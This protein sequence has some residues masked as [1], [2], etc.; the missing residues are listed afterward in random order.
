MAQVQA[1]SYI[2]NAPVGAQYKSVWDAGRTMLQQHYQGFLQGT[3]HAFLP[4]IFANTYVEEIS[5]DG[6][7]KPGSTINPKDSQL[8]GASINKKGEDFELRVFQRF[9][10]ILNSKDDDSVFQD[11]HMLWK[12]FAIDSFKVNALLKDHPLL[13]KEISQFRKKYTTKRATTFGECDMV[14][15]V[16]DIGLVVVEIKGPISKL[17]KG[18]HQCSRMVDFSSHAFESCAQNVPI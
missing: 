9:E 1:S 3:S 11:C 16:K 13:Q 2:H 4:P 15:L 8:K 17:K 5:A 6:S 10:H 7:I 14:V 12:G 18:V